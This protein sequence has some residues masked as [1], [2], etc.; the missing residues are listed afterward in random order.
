MNIALEKQKLKEM[1]DTLTD[2]N[3]L[4]FLKKIIDKIRMDR[5]TPFSK[6]EL[7]QRALESEEAIK[8]NRFSSLEDLEKEMKNW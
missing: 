4:A 8:E 3:S 2:E 1:I 6:Q 7:V 5:H